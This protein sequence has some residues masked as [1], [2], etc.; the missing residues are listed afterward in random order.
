MFKVKKIDVNSAH[1][2]IALINSNEAKELSLNSGDKVKIFNK[3]TRN[4]IFCELDIIEDSKKK[5]CPLNKLEIGLFEHAFEKLNVKEGDL[6]SISPSNKPKSLEYVKKKFQGYKLKSYEYDEII[7]D[8]ST[9]LYSEIETTFFVLACSIHKLDF[10]ETVYLTQAMVKTG[11]SLDFSKSDSDIIVDK[12]C[13]GGVPNNRTSMLVIPIVA[14]AGLKIPKTSSRAITSPS[15]TADTMEILANVSVSLKDMYKIVNEENA[16][17]VWGGAFDLSP[18]DDIIIHVEHPLGLDF[19]VQMIASILSKKKSAGSK[20]VLI[21]IPIG[22][23]AKVRDEIHANSLKEKFEKVGKAIGLDIVVILTDGSEVVGN[24]IGPLL[25]A[26]DVLDILSNKPNAPYDLR[27]KA[28]IMSGILFRMAGHVKT[29]KKGYELAENILT[30]GKAL[31]K[32]KAIIKKQ[33][34]KKMPDLA[35]FKE[36]LVCTKNG[37][38]TEISIKKLTKL[39]NLLGTP[40][41]KAA[42][43]YIPKKIGDYVKK[44]E[45][46]MTLYSNS[47]IKLKYA[48]T[49]LEERCSNIVKID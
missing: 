16:C 31:D 36:E 21:D 25:E 8:I 15:G 10:K 11:K 12:H 26:I 27:E 38:I 34:E 42:G 24:G 1:N 35:K 23:E 43:I 2:L 29:R 7:M 44:G 37:I 45:I 30:S 6:V 49:C 48:L 40:K 41:D 3:K 33:G 5:V 28:L 14:A 32:F 13:I 39:A 22:P 47:E 17:L 4:H 20:K 19:E 46:L 18:A 9:N